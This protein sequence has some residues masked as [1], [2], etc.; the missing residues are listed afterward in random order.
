MNSTMTDLEIVS[1][2]RQAKDRKKQLTIL[3]QLCDCSVDRIVQILRSHGEIV[4][5]RTIGEARKLEKLGPER[6]VEICS[7]PEPVAAPLPEPEPEK[8]V[9]E[10]P[11]PVAA[12]LPE[13]EPELEPEPEPEPVSNLD[14]KPNQREEIS[15]PA[16]PCLCLTAVETADLRRLLDRVWAHD[17]DGSAI[18][19]LGVATVLDFLL[20]TRCGDAD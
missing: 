3:A 1:T 12:P 2:W 13:P 19:A 5:S 6:L 14:T 17:P 20:R 4:Q 18:A 9:L 7:A 15:V 10:E 8:F 16:L 11:E